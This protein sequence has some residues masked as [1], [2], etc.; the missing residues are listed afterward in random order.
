MTTLLRATT[1][2]ALLS[3][4]AWLG[5]LLHAF[6]AIIAP[7]V[8]SQVPVQGAAAATS[9]GLPALRPRGHG[10][11]RDAA[12]CTR[13]RAPSR[14]IPFH[15][16]RPRARRA[17]GRR[18]R[19]R[20]LRG[21][22]RLAAHR[23]AARGGRR[24]WPGGRGA[25]A[26]ALARYC[27]AAR[28]DGGLRP[29]RRRR[30]LAVTARGPVPRATLDQR[31]TPSCRGDL[32]RG[33]A[34][35]AP[36]CT[37]PYPASCRARPRRTA[38]RP[39]H[40]WL[41]ACQAL[42][43][44]SRHSGDV[45]IQAHQARRAGVVVLG[46]LPLREG[47]S[48]A[49]EDLRALRSRPALSSTRQVQHRPDTP[50]GRGGLHGGAA[51]SHLVER[52]AGVVDDAHVAVPGEALGA[53]TPQFVVDAGAASRACTGRRRRRRR[54]GGRRTRG[55]AGTDRRWR[56]RR[57]SRGSR[58]PRAGRPAWGCTPP[59][60][61]RQAATARR[62]GSRTGSSGGPGSHGPRTGL[63]I[64]ASSGVSCPASTR[65]T[66]ERRRASASAPVSAALASTPPPAQRSGCCTR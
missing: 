46:G 55:P 66:S 15:A 30:L 52:R 44:G 60:R 9:D 18:R 56:S 36:C 54:K 1:A 10:L 29:R 2:V 49:V 59:G 16:P 17:L 39:R 37:R 53:R 38:A 19:C 5:G 47:G 50:R 21:R 41:Q 57:D 32:R 34:R 61:S 7:V 45:S 13:R 23:R 62:T 26:R 12:R 25:R 24:P 51:P 33:A 28:Q 27:R 64:R 48:P 58:A 14:G 6:G 4:A 40:V 31:Q 65:C 22:G 63:R 11:R 8:F 20:R 35:L 42:R 43:R 3:L